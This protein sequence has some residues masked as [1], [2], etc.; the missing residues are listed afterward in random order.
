MDRS[1]PYTRRQDRRTQLHKR[2]GAVAALGLAGGALVYALSTPGPAERSI[3]AD[4]APASAADTAPTPAAQEEALKPGQRRV[5]PHSIVPGGVTGVRDL[6]RVIREDKVVAAHYAEFDLAKAHEKTVTTPRAVH[7]SYRKGDKVYWTAKKLMLAEGETLIS[8]GSHEA[9]ARCANQ[10]SDTPRLPVEAH[11]PSAEELDSAVVEGDPAAGALENVGYGLPD[12]GPAGGFLN[13]PGNGA[14]GIL[15]GG[16]ES[17]SHSLFAANVP[18]APYGAYLGSR[19]GSGR[20]GSGQSGSGGTDGGSGANPGDTSGAPS[21]NNTGASGGAGSGTPAASTPVTAAPGAGA[22]ATGTPA[23]GTPAAGTPAAGNTNPA[24]APQTGATQPSTPAAPATPGGGSG[25]TSPGGTPS[26][27]SQP[28]LPSPATPQAPAG[29]QV[30]G[31]ASDIG[32]DPIP[33]GTPVNPG[34]PAGSP[35]SSPAPQPTL[36]APQ[37]PTPATGD[38]DKPA[39]V[40]EPGSLWLVGAALGLMVVQRRRRPA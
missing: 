36:N 14:T 6:G 1:Y 22:P 37:D 12:Q 27:P 35:D 25:P 23:A 32:V 28:P 34:I 8:D 33:G 31:G 11:G 38:P 10:I 17:A 29:G 3:I 13:A 2:L 15:A 16:A 7:V 9:R 4:T 40:P 21:G 20:G 24:P 26:T 39:E 5:Y 19:G 18:G 30:G